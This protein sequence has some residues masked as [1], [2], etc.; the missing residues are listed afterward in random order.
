M[1]P[2]RLAFLLFLSDQ[3]AGGLSYYEN[4][5][6]AIRIASPD[7][8]RLIGILNG[9]SDHTRVLSQL[10]EV[11]A[12]PASDLR[13]KMMVKV[14]DWM[15]A[16]SMPHRFMPELALSRMLKITKADVVFATLLPGYS[17]QVPLV[18]WIPDFQFRHMP[19]LFN[20]ERR[21]WLERNAH[22][23]ATYSHTVIL[24]SQS[25]LKDY[26]D[27]VPNQANKARVVHFVSGV[28]TDVYEKDPVWICEEYRL[29]ERFFFLPNQ[30]WRHKNHSI[31][32]KALEE[33]KKTQSDIRV[34][35]SGLM[36]DHRDLTYPSE[37]MTDIS[38]NGLR[39]NFILLG[40]VPRAHLYP[41]MRQSLAVLQPSL[42]EGWNTSVEEA[43]TLG[44]G[45]VMSDIPVHREQNP[46]KGAYF[47]PDD[48]SGLAALLV[49]IWNK[50]ASGPDVELERD[51]RERF[52]IRI[53]KFGEEFLSVV[54]QA[55]KDK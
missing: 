3:W 27:I 40:Y 54:R 46:P 23:L 35:A 10:D 18:S 33:V 48:A 30:F 24:S 42:F 6:K 8:I 17:S 4:L 29:P 49:D 34:V 51:A 52:P 1:S 11:Y 44:K 13:E 12:V 20:P 36:S 21:L 37:L 22:E 45:V 26:C 2:I 41:L 5:F 31:V 16:R 9:N 55:A 38:R 15:R 25:A 19:E 50:G 32:L 47:P 28:D 7:E 43:R 39:E 14:A 53:R